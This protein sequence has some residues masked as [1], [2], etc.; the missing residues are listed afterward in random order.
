M[1]FTEN[2]KV[3]IDS[4]FD[5]T[6]FKRLEKNIASVNENF[7]SMGRFFRRAKGMGN[8]VQ[9]AEEFQDVLERA[10][11]QFKEMS[12]QQLSGKLRGNEGFD[13]GEDFDKFD[14]LGGMFVDAND[15]L[16]QMGEALRRVSFLISDVGP[17][18]F[19]D[20]DGEP[21]PAVMNP[22][23]KKGFPPLN[24]PTDDIPTPDEMFKDME[25]QSIPVDFRPA[26]RRAIP[27]EELRQG[28][29]KGSSGLF[30][31]RGGMASMFAQTGL[32]A[33]N[34]KMARLNEVSNLARSRVGGLGGGVRNL[35][36]SLKAAAPEARNLQMKLL[37][38][39]FT[40]LT[41]AFIFGGLAMGALGAV[42]AFEVLSN[43]L[44][45]FFLPS[46]LNV[47]DVLLDFQSFVMGLDRDTREFFG[48]L[49]IGVAVFAA[50][51]GAV[52]ALAKPLVSIASLFSTAGLKLGGLLTTI[53]GAGDDV[54]GFFSTLKQ[55]GSGGIFGG[56]KQTA[57]VIKTK[58]VAAFKGLSSI[59]IGI[60]SKIATVVNS[61]FTLGGSISAIGALASFL[62]G[63]AAG[64]L[65]VI[66]VAKEF[67]KKVALIFGTVLAV[68]AGVAAFFL[69][70][71]ALVVA[72]V[73]V[74][75]GALLGLIFTFR[76]ELMAGVMFVVKGVISLISG[77]ITLIISGFKLLVTLITNI[78]KGLVNIVKGIAIAIGAV[79]K[80]ILTGSFEKIKKGLGL[81]VKGIKQVFGSLLTIMLAPFIALFNM[82][83]GNSIIPEMVSDIIDFIMSI[84]RKI[85]NLGANIVSV[86]VQGIK[87]AGSAIFDAFK[88]ILPDFLV[89]AIE[90]AG[91]A[92]KGIA[93]AGGKIVD[94]AGNVIKG[95]AEAGSDLLGGG[96]K[97]SGQNKTEITNNQFDVTAE[98]NNSEETA[99]ETGRQLGRGLNQEFEGRKNRRNP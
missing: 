43:T 27:E 97:N 38:L 69:S 23:E 62:G 35:A 13:V 57:S 64:F 55:I 73:G 58:L 7:Q 99:G 30:G 59:L 75:I 15:E 1:S 72:A 96:N 40:M 56:L 39:Q 20:S 46:A 61:I 68:V 29:N 90:G 53:T 89:N 82:L 85:V 49:F 18:P 67:G 91:K 79:I 77:L 54:K 80:G 21:I 98:V 93:T 95:A 24:R 36:G 83:I 66:T 10:N 8:M 34:L 22:S 32:G 81:L 3:K 42:G 92:V 65:S 25:G 37:G 71:P 63:L 52:A 9:E 11:L 19:K 6:G 86:I 5:S 4:V 12:G 60:G 16:V 48:N 31:G 84:P 17:A 14:A 33:F 87:N 76:D 41:V 2:I 78:I 50:L 94:A 74:M 28:P 88:K 70:I 51:L 45:F 47:L 26:S 44:T